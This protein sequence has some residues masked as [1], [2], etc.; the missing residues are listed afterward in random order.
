MNVA[1]RGL[2]SSSA[3]SKTCSDKQ[4]GLHLIFPVERG[5]K[6]E[7]KRSV[8]AHTSVSAN[9]FFALRT[10]LDLSSQEYTCWNFS[11]CRSGAIS[12]SLSITACDH[13][14]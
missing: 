7:Y 4:A 2:D 8:N 5:S 3:W 9:S 14:Y 12:G 1:R 13:P 10:S 6:C 11:Y